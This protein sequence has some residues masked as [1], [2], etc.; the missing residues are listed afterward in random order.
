MRCEHGW[1]KCETW[2]KCEAWMACVTARR[3]NTRN[4]T[5]KWHTAN[6]KHIHISSLVPFQQLTRSSKTRIVAIY[7]GPS[8]MLVFYNIVFICYKG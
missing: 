2:M 4:E 7:L 1:M 6:T 5:S 8:L 3:H